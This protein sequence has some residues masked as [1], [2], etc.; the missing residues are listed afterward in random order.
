MVERQ[1]A[2]QAEV[3]KRL[4][5]NSVLS[6]FIAPFPDLL[7]GAKNLQRSFERMAE[8]LVDTN[9]ARAI[10]FSIR[11]GNKQRHWCLVLSPNECQVAEVKAERPNLE[12]LTDADTWSEV[13]KGNLSPLEAFGLGKLR[14][15]GDV[16]LARLLVRRLQKMTRTPSEDAAEEGLD[17]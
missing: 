15:R 2:T 7:G 13:A 8:S 12:I 1:L 11:E 3:A 6:D 5:G 17:G 16:R 10:Q 14:V 9:T 4:A